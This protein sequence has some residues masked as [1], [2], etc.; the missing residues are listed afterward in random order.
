MKP[1][2]LLAALV[3][4]IFFSCEKEAEDIKV[5]DF[6]HFSIEV[7]EDWQSF[8]EQGYDSKVGGVTNGRDKLIYDYG[9]YSYDFINQTSDTHIRTNTIIDGRPA[10]IVQP[11]KK[12]EGIIG[13]YVEVDNQMKFNLYG[14]NIE[15]NAVVLKI[16]DSLKFK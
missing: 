9:M 3:F 13:V 5:L 7:P 6:E 15:E 11:K 10:L 16:F 4:F 2:L 12:G 1:Q 14:E 8:S